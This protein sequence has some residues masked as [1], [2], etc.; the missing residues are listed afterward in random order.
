M[1][2]SSV[3]IYR[4]NFGVPHIYADKEAAGYFGL[5]YAE[6]A[7]QLEILLRRHLQGRGELA[8]AFGPEFIE[9][10]LQAR[11]WMH[12]EE[13]QAGF[14]RM[15][16]QLQGNYEQ[17]VAGVNRYMEE[18][19]EAVPDWGRPLEPIDPVIHSR[20]IFWSAYQAGH[21]IKA[22]QNG[23]V[24]LSPRA[25]AQVADRQKQAS[26]E[27]F[28]APWRTAENATMVLTDP[29]GGID[30][31]FVYEARL[32][33]GEIHQAGY[34]IGP[35]PLLL[36]TRDIA[37]AMT[38]GSP[39]VSDCYEVE[40][41]PDNPRRYRFDGQWQ[42]MITRD[43]TIEVAGGESV[44]RT[45]EYTRHNEVLSPVVARVDDKAYIISTPY[46]HIAGQYDE[47]LYRLGL[48]KNVR[49][50]REAL[51]GLGMFSQNVL[52][53]D[54]AGESFYVR[55]GRTPRRPE[56]YDWT[57]PVPGNTSETA[58]Q[59]IH[60]LADLVHIENPPQGYMQNCNVWPALMWKDSPLTPDHYP[61]YIYN[62]DLILTARGER[63]IE[64]LSRAANFTLADAFELVLDE[65]WI[66]SELWTMALT[67]AVENQ[68]KLVASKGPEF[69][70]VLHGLLNFNGY[71][72]AD[73]TE[74]LYHYY[75]RDINWSLLTADD[76]GVILKSVSCDKPIDDRLQVALLDGVSQVTNKLIKEHGT[77]EHRLGDVFRIGKAGHS[78]PIGGISIMSNDPFNQCGW[79]ELACNMTMR[80]F[81]DNVLDSQK[82]PDPDENGHRFV[83]MGSRMLLLTVLTDPVQSFSL[84]NFGQSQNP[85]SPHFIDQARMFSERRLKPVY[86]EKAE[87][88]P[89]VESTVILD[90]KLPL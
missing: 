88:M 43:V 21:G 89:H 17:Y 90:V 63:A 86:F 56:G 66:S 65:K 68:P 10:D 61:D 46:M 45:F 73:S 2:S 30:G 26:N 12:T 62:E 37:W 72:R 7:D 8:V 74:A 49:E 70:R 82:L 29:H 76:F 3:T 24:Q 19:P 57:H 28:L 58:W 5:G 48:A 4:D 79:H 39:L 9:S 75:W 13:A 40:V 51:S 31:T 50:A 53:G 36:H 64:I 47:D 80:A 6:A 42:E 41:D 67:K 23:G 83:R 85:D 71:A 1:E 77:T 54:K 27:W 87:L 11:G 16:P 55:I 33:A 20:D 35:S 69:R 22:C 18:H 14:N 44:T 78:F 81:S 59:G 25:E 60:P 32:H 84:H 34:Y 52:V 38:T 15:S